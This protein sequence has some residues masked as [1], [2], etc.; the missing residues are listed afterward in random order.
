[1]DVLRESIVR[2]ASEQALLETI[3]RTRAALLE[4]SDLEPDAVLEQLR[5][6]IGAE[7]EHAQRHAAASNEPLLRAPADTA[8]WL[9]DQ[10]LGYGDLG[11]LMRTESVQTIRIVGPH[12]LYV[13]DNGRQHRM[14]GIRFSSDRA[15]R[16]LV[17]R[18][19]TLAGRLFDDAHPRVDLSLPDGSRLHAVMPPISRQYTEVTIR[20]FTLFERRIESLVPDTMTASVAR[21]LTACVNARAN[22]LISGDGGTGKTT[23]QRMLLL[24]I[25]DPDEWLIVFETTRELGLDRLIGQCQSWQARDR[26]T[27]GAGG[28]SLS[29]LLEEDGLRCEASRLI[30]GECR[31]EEAYTVLHALETGHQGTVTTLHARSAVD[32]LERLL[33]AAQH[34]PMAPSEAVL[35]AMIRRN[36]DVVVHLKKLHGRRLVSEVVEIERTP[37]TDGGFGIRPLW[38]R[39]GAGPLVRQPYPPRLLETFE[40]LALDYRWGDAGPSDEDEAA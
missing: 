2:S 17:K 30:V 8:Q 33:T 38:T 39:K 22:V 15:V 1:M 40:E 35:R 10:V 19:A 27:D 20:R 37:G 29:Q 21:F 36:I 5:A 16:D 34:S 26:G 23:L 28:I 13:V 12:R 6:A 3:L 32:A 11:P 7:I 24:G 25:D 9:D 18:F 31:K 4:R 14:A